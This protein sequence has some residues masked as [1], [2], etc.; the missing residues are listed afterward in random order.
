MALFGN[1]PVGKED[2]S[3]LQSSNIIGKGTKITGD[4][5]TQGNFRIDGSLIG[6]IR[7]K[8][9]VILGQGS[10]V[11]GNIFAQNAEIEGEIKGKLEIADVLILHPT[12]VVHGDIITGKLIVMSGARFNGLC[13]MNNQQGAS[14]NNVLNN[15]NGVKI[16]SQAKATV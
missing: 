4:I 7:S 12:A 1:K 9:K 10:F 8:S 6:N 16:E 11:E 13:Q 5:E 3:H 14:G 15:K 2:T